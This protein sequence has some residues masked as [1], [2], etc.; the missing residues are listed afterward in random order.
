[1]QDESHHPTLPFPPS[2]NKADGLR[3][4][5]RAWEG[6]DFFF[7]FSSVFVLGDFRS[8]PVAPEKGPATKCQRWILKTRAPESM[9]SGWLLLQGLRQ[10]AEMPWGCKNPVPAGWAR[11]ASRE[12]S[13]LIGSSF[14]TRGRIKKK[15]IKWNFLLLSSKFPLICPEGKPAALRS[16]SFFFFFL[17]SSL[18]TQMPGGA[19]W[20]REWRS[21]RSGLPTVAWLLSKR[22][23]YFSCCHVRFNLGSIILKG[24][25]CSWQEGVKWDYKL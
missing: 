17:S 1:M 11:A 21:R 8:H 2:P 10:D 6:G 9:G 20:R 24:W 5:A 4:E 22:G 18:S 15:K 14:I 25:A 13:G 19:P 23:F 3:A 12:P 16:L 7:F